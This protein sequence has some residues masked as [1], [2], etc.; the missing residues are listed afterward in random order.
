MSAV[1]AKGS[2]VDQSQL[3]LQLKVWK[4]LA[5]S[6]QLLM[7]T[8]AVALKL[9]PECTQEELK[10]ALEST[11]KKIAE[12]E[13]SVATTREQTRQSLLAME[14][15]LAASI[16]AQN[17]AQTTATELRTALDKNIQ[18]MAVERAAIA[19]DLQKLKEQVVEKDK[20]LKAINTALADTPDNVLKKMKALKKE[21]QDEAD[22][23]RQVE[24]SL[25]TVSKEKRE[26]DQ[27]L[28]TLQENYDKLVPQHRELHAL[29]TSLHEQLKP[30]VKD[31]SSL[32]A[33]PAL[34]EKALGND[35]SE[36][37]KQKGK[38]KQKKAIGRR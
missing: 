37:D 33:V 13:A 32:A 6:K 9:D 8:A 11:V 10:Q 26:Q 36:D 2:P 20:A 30:L 38:D 27:K 35:E 18:D 23:R 31:A 7:R 28:K 19:K 17:V 34:D 29:A 4:D 24:A 3:E 5:I 15:K 12:S 1:L 16:Q 14:Q 21:K 25:N 22:A